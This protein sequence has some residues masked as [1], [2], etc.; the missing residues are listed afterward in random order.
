MDRIYRDLGNFHNTSGSR[1]GTHYSSFKF[2]PELEKKNAVKSR[3]WP[4]V[5]ALPVIFFFSRKIFFLN[6]FFPFL[7]L[8]NHEG[9]KNQKNLKKILMKNSYDKPSRYNVKTFWIVWNGGRE[10]SFK[11]KYLVSGE[12]L[13]VKF[14][15]LK[16]RGHIWSYS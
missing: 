16:Y 12:N 11:K 13:V 2:C 3:F 5:A 9:E 1:S 7:E 4:N 15:R 14:I 8:S 6:F 10:K